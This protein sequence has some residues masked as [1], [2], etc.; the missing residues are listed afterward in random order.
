M[1]RYVQVAFW[2]PCLNAAVLTPVRVCCGN[3]QMALDMKM[4]LAMLNSDELMLLPRVSA[5]E[6]L[7]TIPESEIVADPLAN[8]A[9]LAT[10]N[11]VRHSAESWRV[12]YLM[13]EF[14]TLFFM[15]I[16]T[17]DYRYVRGIRGNQDQSMGQA[18]TAYHG[19]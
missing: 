13:L 15:V 14:L 3:A 17:G 2:F 1:R 10:L 16:V 4:Q 18:P 5:E 8:S 7:K 9:A 11:R 19:H 6:N 12:I